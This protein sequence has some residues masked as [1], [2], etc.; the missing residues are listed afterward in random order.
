M[1]GRERGPFRGAR[2]RVLFVALFA[3]G[4]LLFPPPRATGK[5]IVGVPVFKL[6]AGSG[7]SMVVVGAPAR[8][9]HPAVVL[10]LVSGPGGEVTYSARATAVS[11]TSIQADLGAL[12]RIDV[13]YSASGRTKTARSACGGSPLRY[14]AGFFEGTIDFAGEE[15]YTEVTA[16][17]AAVDPEFFL[18]LVCPGDVTP[19]GSGPG[20]PGAELRVRPQGDGDGVSFVAHK[21]TPGSRAGFIATVSEKRDGIGIARG[22]SVRGLPGAFRYRHT[23]RSAAV[24]PPAPFSGSAVF[25]RPKHG[26]AVWSGSLAVD[27][28][29]RSDVSLTAGMLHAGIARTTWGPTRR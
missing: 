20:L 1:T 4:C 24:H 13:A 17:R 28:P 3:S 15:G 23:L 11:A 21:N 22:V 10:V 18:D 2:L 29:G 27:F 16:T 7:Y 5:K 26:P 14:D 19:T 9:S 6:R 25:R 12:G 8:G